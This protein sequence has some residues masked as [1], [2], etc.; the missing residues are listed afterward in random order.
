MRCVR[1][2]QEKEPKD[3]AWRDKAKGKRLAHCRACQAKYHRKHYEQNRQRYIDKAAQRT[4]RVLAANRR[5]LLA[6]L[7]SR[8]CSDCG[9]SDPVVLEFDHLY[10]KEFGI[11]QALRYRSWRSIVEEIS[12][13]DVVCVN[14]HRRR[15]ASRQGGVRF[16]FVTRGT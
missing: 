9:E 10:E 4:D 16:R 1:C 6:V 15:T 7:R 2:G 5:Q 12:K 8:A 3:F 11:S 14:C 13:C